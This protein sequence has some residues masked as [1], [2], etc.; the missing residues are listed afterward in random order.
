MANSDLRAEQVDPR[1]VQ[2]EVDAPVY[3][4]YFTGGGGAT[5]EYRL[6]GATDVREV[7]EWGTTNAAGR[8][9]Q[10]FVETDGS[11]GRRLDLLAD[12]S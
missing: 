5:D 11:G 8:S 1:D 9:F 4:V 10:L 6:T 3:R 12:L 2:V 7:L